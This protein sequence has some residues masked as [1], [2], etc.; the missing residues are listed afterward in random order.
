M[1]VCIISITTIIISVLSVFISI[2]GFLNKNHFKAQSKVEAETVIEYE[3]SEEDAGGSS[4]KKYTL[5]EPEEKIPQKNTSVTYETE[6]YK[7]YILE[8]LIDSLN[9]KLKEQ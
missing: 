5:V 4:K 1:A 8:D 3:P 9:E 6:T 7:S 2:M